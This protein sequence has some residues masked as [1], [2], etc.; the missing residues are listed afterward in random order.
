MSYTEQEAN[1]LIARQ[2]AKLKQGR[3]TNSKS[4]SAVAPTNEI[5]AQGRFEPKSKTE[6]A[7]KKRLV[8]RLPFKLPTWN[9]LLA[10]DQWKRK[11]IRDMIHVLISMFI[12]LEGDSLTPMEYQEK[13][14]LM[15]SYIAEYYRMI[16]PKKSVKSVTAKSE[17]ARTKR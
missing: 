2:A 4:M 7:Q 16:A 14:Q 8:I 12:P 6:P 11:K 5:V 13:R 17:P 3:P 10:S 15:A 1:E 9:V